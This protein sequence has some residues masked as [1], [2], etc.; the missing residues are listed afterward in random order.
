MGVEAQRRG[1]LARKLHEIRPAGG[2]LHRHPLDLA[3]GIL[4]ADDPGRAASFPIVSGVMSMTDRPGM[5]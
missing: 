5:L 4:D 3:G 2:A 1:I